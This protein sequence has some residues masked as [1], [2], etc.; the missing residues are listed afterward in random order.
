MNEN[1]WLVT[2]DDALLWA[3]VDNAQARLTEGGML[4]VTRGAGWF[5][6]YAAYEFD[7]RDVVTL[8][9]AGEDVEAPIILK[10]VVGWARRF[11]REHP[12]RQRQEFWRWLATAPRSVR[13]QF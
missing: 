6:T 10:I 1:N 11:G 8:L 13:R 9:I 4:L 12:N 7:M 2:P 3:E 5:E